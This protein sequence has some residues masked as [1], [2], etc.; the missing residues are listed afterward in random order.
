MESQQERIGSRYRPH[1]RRRELLLPEIPN[2]FRIALAFAAGWISSTLFAAFMAS[3]VS[4]T[5]AI[6]SS[7]IA[8]ALFLAAGFAYSRF[9]KARLASDAPVQQESESEAN[10]VTRRSGANILSNG[11]EVPANRE[12]GKSDCSSAN[13]SRLASPAILTL[14]Q[15]CE[16]YA[17]THSLTPRQGEVLRLLADG[18]PTTTIADELYLSKD[19]VK[20]HTKAIYAKAGVHSRQELLAALYAQGE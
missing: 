11:E 14:D 4:G 16:A 1:A 5:A 10:S 6:A 13:P 3:S 19:T 15:R 8:I 7:A 12:G 9:A 2:T 17:Q 18:L 20:T